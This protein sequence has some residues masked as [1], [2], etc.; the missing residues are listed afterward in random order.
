MLKR[1]T[2]QL[3][4]VIPWA[5][6]WFAKRQP[7]CIGCQIGYDILSIGFGITKKALRQYTLHSQRIDRG[8]AGR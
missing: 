1:R 7:P 2:V 6:S 8:E 5:L 4:G 3:A